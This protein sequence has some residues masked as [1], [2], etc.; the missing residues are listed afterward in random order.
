MEFSGNITVS[1]GEHATLSLIDLTG[2]DDSDDEP[3]LELFG[4]LA[5]LQRHLLQ[6]QPCIDLTRSP[7]IQILSQ[8]SEKSLA[9]A[10]VM[11]MEL[12]GDSGA[13]QTK[14]CFPQPTCRR[15]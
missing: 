13:P 1:D 10:R 7:S 3:L 8:V 2:S 4:S 9:G 11:S 12:A 15:E 14:A 6:Q 5:A